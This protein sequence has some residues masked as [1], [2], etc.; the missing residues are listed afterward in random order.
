MSAYALNSL[1]SLAEQ[2]KRLTGRARTSQLDRIASRLLRLAKLPHVRR[3]LRADLHTP[4]YIRVP[5][6][7]HATYHQIF[8]QREYD[9]S[10]RRNPRVIVDAGANVGLAAVLFANRYPDARIF[11]IEP[12]TSNFQLL[13]RNVAP[14]PQITPLHAALWDKD[15]AVN[16]IDEGYGEWGFMTERAHE[17]ATSGRERTRRGLVRGLSVDTL[18]REHHIDHIDLFKIDIE[19]A[20]REVMSNSAAWMDRIG[21]MVVELHDGMKPGCNRS[22]YRATNNFDLEW[23]QGENVVVARTNSCLQPPGQ[24]AI[25]VRPEPCNDNNYLLDVAEDA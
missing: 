14:Y 18:L 20:E 24:G 17:K 12:D 2:L 16:V 25:R 11:A 4:V 23:R 9:F 8:E 10:V 15:E 13:K 19:G 3:I 6:S 7:D 22:F 1:H 21:A 5:S